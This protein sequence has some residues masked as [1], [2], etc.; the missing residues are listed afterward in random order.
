MPLVRFAW[1][2]IAAAVVSI[3]WAAVGRLRHP[4][5]VEQIGI[6][7]AISIAASLVNFAVSRV[8]MQA[9]RAHHS[10]ALEADAR[11]LLTDVDR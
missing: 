1:L 6:G 3:A 7:L 10:I 11:H 4:R 2:S 9:G 8:L 5:A